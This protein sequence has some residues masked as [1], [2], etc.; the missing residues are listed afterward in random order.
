MHLPDE[1]MDIHSEQSQHQEGRPKV[2]DFT[3]DSAGNV[4]PRP[5]KSGN[6]TAG[7][8]TPPHQEWRRSG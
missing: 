2:V 7:E 4:S 3:V 1:N 8:N 6:Q 5:Q